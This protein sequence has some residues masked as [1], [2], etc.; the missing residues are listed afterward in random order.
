M[1]S[2]RPMDGVSRETRL[3]NLSRALRR[4]VSSAMSFLFQY[5]HFYLIRCGGLSPHRI[6]ALPPELSLNVSDFSEE[7]LRKISDDLP[8]DLEIIRFQLCG[9]G[10]SGRT[11]VRIDDRGRSIGVLFLVLVDELRSPSGYRYRLGAGERATWMFGTYIDEHYRRR[12]YFVNLVEAAFAR[13]VSNGTGA[14]VGEVHNKNFVS[15][16]AHLGMGFAV[17]KHI[18]Y[19]KLLG[20]AWYWEGHRA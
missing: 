8:L 16:K 4:R 11:I 1:K 7:T 20:K 12:G 13:A 14:L 2:K 18:H 10:S 5:D 17:F 6:R 19:I 9:V 3:R 15:M